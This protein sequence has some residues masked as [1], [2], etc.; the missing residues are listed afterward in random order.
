MTHH[1]LAPLAGLTAAL[2]AALATAPAAP[3]ASPRFR[4]PISARQLIVVSSSSYNPSAHLST[5]RAYRRAGPS[6]A[7]RLAFGPWPAEIGYGG[8]RDSRREGDGSTPTGVY[9][10]GARVYGN[11][12]NP[13]RLHYAYHRLR[14]GD[15]WD[16]DPFSAGYNQFVHVPCG[17]APSFAAGSEA[18]WRETVAYPYFAVIRFNLAPT[19]GGRNAPGSAIFLHSWVNGPTAGCVALPAARLLA[20]LRWLTPDGHP[21]IEIGTDREVG[22]LP[23]PS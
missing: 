15:W 9:A 22:A 12:P 6:Q 14:C 4:V 7:W 11:R 10:I 17:A 1:L 2:A 18:L 19:L 21:V 23:P 13:G 3:A 20:I 8:L 16:E 5:L